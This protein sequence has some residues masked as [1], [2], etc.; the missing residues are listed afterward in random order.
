MEYLI[1]HLKLDHM[2]K[3]MGVKTFLN[4]E[5]P[6]DENEYEQYKDQEGKITSK[7]NFYKDDINIENQGVQNKENFNEQGI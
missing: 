2:V 4:E 5:I 6:F 1:Q 3:K 7:E